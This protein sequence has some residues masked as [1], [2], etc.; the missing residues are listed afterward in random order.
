MTNCMFCEKVFKSKYNYHSERNLKNHIVHCKK[1]P[2][3]EKYK[4]AYC[5]KEEDRAE[6]IASHVS[7]CKENPNYENILKRKKEVGREGRPHS[8]ESKEKISKARIKYLKDNPDKV[9]YLLNHSSKESYPEKYFTQLFENEK[10]D[11]IKKYRIGLYE[12][13][14]CILDKKINIEIDGSQHYLDKK[15]VKSDKRRNLF[16]ESKGWKIIRVN[17]SEYKKLSY[18]EKSKYISN[19]KL[20]IRE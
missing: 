19:I 15:I 5:N 12:L 10:I 14:F 4:C 18:D 1:N 20:I 16:L 7:I 17:W 3:R 11:I 8:K 9:P 13:D 6:K 2:N